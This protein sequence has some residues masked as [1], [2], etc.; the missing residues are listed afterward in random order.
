MDGID[1]NFD[2]R[3]LVTGVKEHADGVR[4]NLTN[5]LVPCILMGNDPPYAL[6]LG[7]DLGRLG[8]AGLVFNGMMFIVV[9]HE[10]AHIRLRH[11]STA[12][13]TQ[14]RRYQMEMEA[15]GL[16][17]AYALNNPWRAL[18]L[19]AGWAWALAAS[20]Q[21]LVLSFI[22]M[23]EM[24]DKIMEDMGSDRRSMRTHPPA[25]ERLGGSQFLINEVLN[26]D[27]NAKRF[28]NQSRAGLIAF[29]DEAWNLSVAGIVK[30]IRLRS[31]RGTGIGRATPRNAE[32]R[33]L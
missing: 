7:D 20:A 17:L 25:E 27:G 9:A 33:F 13:V 3:K 26:I 11:V 28:L 1:L 4:L 22:R 15:D 32:L 8:A 2:A 16:A 19:D 10:Y 14:E 12:Q 6:T 18:N 21:S 5:A 31:E 23:L 29:G 30:E 24:G